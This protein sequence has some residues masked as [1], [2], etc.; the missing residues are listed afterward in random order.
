MP[1]AFR[2]ETVALFGGVFEKTV[3][4]SRL[5]HINAPG[6]EQARDAGEQTRGRTG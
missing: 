4:H 6:W 5:T 3:A 2:W 1:A